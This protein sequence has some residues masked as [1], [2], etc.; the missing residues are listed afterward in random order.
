[1]NQIAKQFETERIKGVVIDVASNRANAIMTQQLLPQ[2][3]EFRETMSNEV[4]S[5]AARINELTNVSRLVTIILAANSYER[6]AFDRLGELSQDGNYI[7]QR[8]AAR[9][10]RAI[11]ERHEVDT[12]AT[13]TTIEYRPP[14]GSNPNPNYDYKKFREVFTNTPE[15]AYRIAMLVDS[16]KRTDF[17]QHDKIRICLETMQSDPDLRV[18]SAAGHMFRLGTGFN[19]TPLA[20]AGFADWWKRNHSSLS[21]NIV[22]TKP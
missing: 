16:N 21:T 7:F 17:S 1:M 8:D 3:E 15:Y 5:I 6:A 2:V 14:W 4:H 9:A 20:T 12:T 18:V 10:Y 19:L 22:T 11:Q 13:W